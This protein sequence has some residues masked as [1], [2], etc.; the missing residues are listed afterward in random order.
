ML[1]FKTSIL[2]FTALLLLCTPCWA[3]TAA[4][5]PVEDL[6]RGSN[7]V[8]F[9]FSEFISSSLEKKGL[10]IV[11]MDQLIS[12]MAR[13]RIRR[14]GFLDSA[15]MHNLSVDFGAQFI[16]FTTITQRKEENG[17]SLGLVVH[18]L[19]TTSGRIVWSK[20]Q[21]VNDTDTR[22][23]LALAEPESVNDLW[24]HLV[25][26]L[27]S[28]FSIE[29]ITGTDNNSAE[30]IISNVD[31]NPKYAQSGTEMNCSI[32]QN[33][34]GDADSSIN[35]RLAVSGR[36][37]YPMTAYSKSGLRASW[38][39]SEKEGSKPVSLIIDFTS[40]KKILYLGSY[41]VD[42]SPP[43]L[44]IRLKG[45]KIG[46]NIV[47]SKT[48]PIIPIWHKR[49]PLSRWKISILKKG[50][51][52]VLS[53]EGS[54]DLPDRFEWKGQRKDGTIVDPGMYQVRLQVWDLASN[55]ASITH[56]VE[57]RQHTPQPEVQAN[58]VEDKLVV[59]LQDQESLVLKYWTARILFS[60]GE[61]L[62]EEQ[63]DS[64]PAT[65]T[66]PALKKDEKR[67]LECLVEYHDVLG[68]MG[69]KNIKDL[70][71]L[72][73]IELPVIEEEIIQDEWLES[74]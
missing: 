55:N 46:K 53:N 45:V 67:A 65:I 7:G 51:V 40:D 15:T 39:A 74:F 36:D 72:L 20:S 13:K 41:T 5:F 62:V 52:T 31:I 34:T 56:Q 64:L 66:L 19:Q 21:A 29:N 17:L 33:R 26:D 69:R 35:F 71:Q 11:P 6:S 8:N 27:F 70:R 49:E 24:Y 43:E 50:D 9:E 73:I 54:G 4:V 60:D 68:N 48:L 18:I 32:T 23:M 28:D 47:F 16:I 30:V 25:K 10:D 61:T 57:Y 22:R 12:F 14:L 63:G 37:F 1:F 2:S 42:N 44:D 38:P 59:M 58:L 3:T